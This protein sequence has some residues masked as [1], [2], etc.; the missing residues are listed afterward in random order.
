MEYEVEGST[1]RGRLYKEDME[2][3]V[4]QKDC[5]AC[6]LN[7][8]DAMEHS[9]WKKDDDQDGGWVMLL[10]VPAHPGSPGQRAVKLLLLLLYITSFRMLMVSCWTLQYSKSLL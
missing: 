8:E 5:Q 2:T 6:N 3:E 4:V 9:R 1:P 10:L 7:R